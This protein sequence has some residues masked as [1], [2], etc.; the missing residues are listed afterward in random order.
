MEMEFVKQFEEHKSE[1]RDWIS[2]MKEHHSLRYS[3]L[4]ENLFRIC[5][6]E[7]NEINMV[8]ID[9][10]HYQGT[11]LWFIPRDTYQP[12][13][14]DYVWTMNYY[15]SC[16]G[17]DTLQSIQGISWDDE[18]PSEEQIN[19]YMMLMLHLVQNIKFLSEDE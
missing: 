9:H 18:K 7:W 12:S 14:D 13:Y 17:C 15:G 6:E 10:G 16:C 2:N 8:E 4:V 5:F 19:D 1:V 11:K 3:D